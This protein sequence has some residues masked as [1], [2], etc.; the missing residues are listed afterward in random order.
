MFLNLAGTF[1]ADAL[2]KKPFKLQNLLDLLLPIG[3]FRLSPPP[4][5][6]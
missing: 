6:A 1:G 5:L 4:S 2:L 3:P